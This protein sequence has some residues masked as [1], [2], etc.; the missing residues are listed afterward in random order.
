M[1]V[2]RHMIVHFKKHNL[3]PLCSL[4][5]YKELHEKRVWNHTIVENN[6][7]ECAKRHKIINLKSIRKKVTI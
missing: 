6:C 5:E 2:I 4:P 7:D 1:S 3:K